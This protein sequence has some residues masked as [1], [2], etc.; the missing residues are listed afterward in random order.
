MR[1]RPV[2]AHASGMVPLVRS[3]KG[4]TEFIDCPAVMCFERSRAHPNRGN[5]T[6]IASRPEW[7]EIKNFGGGSNCH[8][9]GSQGCSEN[10]ET[11]NPKNLGLSVRPRIAF[12]CS[13]SISG[14]QNH[15]HY[16]VFGTGFQKGFLNRQRR[17]V[18]RPGPIAVRKG[19]RTRALHRVRQER[20]QWD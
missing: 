11:Q 6:R 16:W 1:P 19:R 10:P 5:E 2:A 12:C 13:T 17:V 20:A 14:G 15:R 3:R 7:G 8:Q 4:M 9:S 18:R